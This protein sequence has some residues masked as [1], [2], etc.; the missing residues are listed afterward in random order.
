MHFGDA[1]HALEHVARLST[2][3]GELSK[4]TAE[5]EHDFPNSVWIANVVVLL[6]TRLI[7]SAFGAASLVCL[8]PVLK[9]LHQP[10]RRKKVKLLHNDDSRHLRKH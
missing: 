6:S 4:S 1:S 8:H 7:E 5:L 9:M 3:P 2:L 10:P